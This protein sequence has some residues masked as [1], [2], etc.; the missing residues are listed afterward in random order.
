MAGKTLFSLGLVRGGEGSLST[1]DGDR[2]FITR[3]GCGL[4]H[5][6]DSDVLRG[7]LD[8]P[9]PE[10]SSDIERHL[11]I[12]RASGP[13]AVAHGHAPGSGPEGRTEGEEHGS[14]AFGASL[15]DAVSQI[16][17]SARHSG[18]DGP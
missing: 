16:V 4:A 17:Q 5:L 8:A 12:Y 15:H 2:L 7:T 6:T 9:P 3:T 18:G 10:A 11:E 14:F 1:W 13:G